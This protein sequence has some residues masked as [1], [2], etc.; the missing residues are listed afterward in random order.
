MIA[1]VNQHIS[2]VI[3]LR[4][5]KWEYYDKLIINFVTDNTLFWK[6][7]FSL[8]YDRKAKKNT[9]LEKG[10]IAADKAKIAEVFNT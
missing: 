7:I 9:L 6:T 10:E 8:F 1:Y 3:M 2:C 4:R 5:R